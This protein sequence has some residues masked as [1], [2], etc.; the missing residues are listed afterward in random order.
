[1]SVSNGWQA[2]N[3]MDE[4]TRV[5]DVDSLKYQ[6]LNAG[7]DDG[8]SMDFSLIA[9][10]GEVLT[11]IGPSGSGKSTLLHLI[12]GF[13]TPTSGTLSIDNIHV[14]SMPVG[15]RPL[16]IV[17]QNHNLFPHLDLFTN[18]AIGVSP[19]L[20][21]SEAQR[22]DVENAIASLE[23]TGLESR[24]PGQ[25]SGGQQQR[26]ALARV[27]VRK[28]RV[29]LL[30]EAFAALGPAQRQ[31]LIERVADLAKQY[32]M[33]VLMVSHQP[34]DARQVSQRTAFIDRG[35]VLALCETRKLLEDHPDPIIRQY[36]GQL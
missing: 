27:L 12:A 11:I 7:D 26:V 5:L 14:D 23:L 4:L 10:S 22:I 19:S 13:L 16:S 9:G 31:E 33:A 36:L 20:K 29:L 25:L 24:R 2:E 35:R 3:T 21:L 8:L 15:Q 17:F 6:Y 34:S 32:D 28:H 1:M 30:D 18:I